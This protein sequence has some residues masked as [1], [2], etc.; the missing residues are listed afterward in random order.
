M[1]LALRLQSRIVVPEEF[2]YLDDGITAIGG[3][4]FEIVRVPGHTPGS[5]T[6][7]FAGYAFTGDTVYR[8]DV[9][10]MPW[11]EED[12][13]QLVASVRGLWEAL[14]DET[15]VYPGHG[16]AA[17]FGTIKQRNVPLRHMLGL[18]VPVTK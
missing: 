18:D 10:R 13:E 2:A 6:V 15:V 7:L 8:D 1:M 12:G 5:V 4:G 3:D 11:P 17:T 16:G 9:W 14:P